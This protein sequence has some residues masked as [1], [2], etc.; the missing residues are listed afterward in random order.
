MAVATALVIIM[1]LLMLLVTVGRLRKTE[2]PPAFLSHD[3][4]IEKAGVVSLMHTLIFNFL[5]VNHNSS[6]PYEY[7]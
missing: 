5:N 2:K 3:F 1:L 7:S 4:E 6:H